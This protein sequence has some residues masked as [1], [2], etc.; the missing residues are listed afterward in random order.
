M[1]CLTNR[2][3]QGLQH[4]GNLLLPLR[5]IANLQGVQEVR[6]RVQG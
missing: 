1:N 3:H 4:L 6:V 2:V 5:Q